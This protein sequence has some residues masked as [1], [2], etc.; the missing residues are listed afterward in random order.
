MPAASP[1]TRP[2]TLLLTMR[3]PCGRVRSVSEDS[4]QP[5]LGDLMGDH[6]E[7]LPRRQRNAILDQPTLA[8]AL[9]ETVK[10][11][12][13]ATAHAT[14]YHGREHPA[15]RQLIVAYNA[16][17]V[18]DWTQRRFRHLTPDGLAE[19]GRYITI[20][21]RHVTISEWERIAE[22]TRGWRYLP[23]RRG[24]I[25]RTRA[26]LLLNSLYRSAGMGNYTVEDH[27][28][29]AIHA[30]KWFQGIALPLWWEA[31]L[32]EGYTPEAAWM[33][34][35]FLIEP[36]LLATLVFR[37]EAHPVAHPDHRQHFAFTA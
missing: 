37:G 1:S 31:R 29:D 2:S 5:F 6:F 16:D 20:D 13:G 21:A 35:G 3:M 28:R 15:M 24:L 9:V 4:Y 12:H 14:P 27:L 17:R 22:S 32:A 36:A 8:K 34:L 7:A 25:R 18:P 23:S 30:D 10:A 19:T 33:M 26:N 11:V